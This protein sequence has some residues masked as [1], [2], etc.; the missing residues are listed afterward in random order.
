MHWAKIKKQN[1][2]L[3]KYFMSLRDLLFDRYSLAIWRGEMRKRWSE[4]VIPT[5][6]AL[7]LTVKFLEDT[8]KTQIHSN[9]ESLQVSANR[10]QL[11]TLILWVNF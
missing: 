10:Q 6:S 7:V 4:K 2:R 9:F 1:V 8:E 3:E 5:L 11:H